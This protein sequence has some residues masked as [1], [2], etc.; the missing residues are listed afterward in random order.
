MSTEQSPREHQPQDDPAPTD[1]QR[2]VSASRVV[3]ADPDVVFDL[4][5]DP[6]LHP[7]WDGNDNTAQ[8]Q[9]AQRI[10]ARGEVF[11]MLNTSGKVRD[12]QVVE[13]EE[14]RLI[15]WQPGEVGQPRPGHLWRWEFA[16]AEGGTLVTHTY[17]WTALTD[18]KRMAKARSTK[19]SNLQA[20]VDRLAAMAEGREQ[21]EGSE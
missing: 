9:D 12:N 2:V 5:A 8:A 19:E 7:R 13:F 10:R 4:V 17:D 16:P 3:H 15:A 21:T 14:G 1:E 11:V 18:E 6:N 20:S